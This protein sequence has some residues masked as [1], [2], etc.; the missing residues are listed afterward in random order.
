LEAAPMDETGPR[1]KADPARVLARINRLA[2]KDLVS[3]EA[4]GG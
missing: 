4:Y 3:R 1:T 2:L